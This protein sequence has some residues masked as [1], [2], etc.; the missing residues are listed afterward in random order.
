MHRD[1]DQRSDNQIDIESEPEIG[2]VTVDECGE[3]S[4]QAGGDEPKDGKVNNLMN[5]GE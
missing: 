4:P 2:A 5:A 1:Y 3:L